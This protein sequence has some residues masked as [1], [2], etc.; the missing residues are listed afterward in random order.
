[1]LAWTSLGASRAYALAAGQS[2]K[3]GGNTYKITEYDVRDREYEVT[4]VSRG[5]RSS[6][7]VVK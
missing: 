6:A 3:A 4:L 2:F 5:L 7:T 1:M